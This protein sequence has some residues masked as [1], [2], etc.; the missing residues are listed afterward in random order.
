MISPELLASTATFSAARRAWP[1]LV[2]IAEIQG[3]PASDFW[4]RAF[5]GE[6]PAPMLRRCK[7]DGSWGEFWNR[8]CPDDCLMFTSAGAL[9]DEAEE[10]ASSG[11]GLAE[12]DSSR[13][14]RTP[15]GAALAVFRAVV[16]G[17]LR[18]EDPKFAMPSKRGLIL[19]WSLGR[20][21][22]LF[23]ARA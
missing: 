16:E 15:D 3:D 11:G 13:S 17:R 12:E 9:A 8:V 19:Y 1:F 5:P 22:K 23:P 20:G 2:D 14:F 6:D 10:A 18:S 4:K 21:E 7:E